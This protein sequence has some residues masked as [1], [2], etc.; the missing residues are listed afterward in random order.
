MLAINLGLAIY[1]YRTLKRV[2]EKEQ[3]LKR[4]DDSGWY[5]SKGRI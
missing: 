1:S 5:S 4:A 2:E 3:A